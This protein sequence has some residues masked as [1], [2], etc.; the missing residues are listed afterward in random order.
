MNRLRK[1]ALPPP[2]AAL[3]VAL[4]FV[5]A[6]ASA[7]PPGQTPLTP[8]IKPGMAAGNPFMPA[9][10]KMDKAMAA[11]PSTGN[12]DADF[13][14]MMIPHHQGAVDMAKIELARGK[15]PMLRRLSRNIIASQERQ[16]R[17]MK[18]WE[19]KHPAGR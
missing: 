7:Q 16:I 13:V 3:A 6:A 2:V 18:A 10:D 14:A 8:G 9:M 17:E 15:D 1:S 12:V 5:S 11:A 19:R 4:L